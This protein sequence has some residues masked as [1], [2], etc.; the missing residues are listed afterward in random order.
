MIVPCD[1]I[2]AETKHY[3]SHVIYSDDKGNTWKL[4]GST[5]QHQVNECAIAELSNGDLMLNM[6]NY[7][8]DHKN[9]KV[10][11]SK[12]GGISWSDIRSDETLIE[13]ICQGSL[14]HSDRAGKGDLFFSNP[15]STDSREKM[16]IRVSS[17]DGKSW[18]KK[19]VVN[20]GPS[21]YSDMVLINK[22]KIGILYEG[23]E[24]SAYEGISFEIV[25]LSEIK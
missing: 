16:T 23:G 5:P 13:P 17:D 8:R 3:Y 18:L 1:H 4:G 21:A 22:K 6:R 7:D 11:L 10:S 24:K 9:R 14:L 19:I 12:D 2:E 20:D 15:A 25:K